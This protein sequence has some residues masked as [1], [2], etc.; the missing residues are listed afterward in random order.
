MEV[1][2][3]RKIHNYRIS[4]EDFWEMLHAKRHNPRLVITLKDKSGKHTHKLSAGY[5]DDID[6]YREGKETFVLSRNPRLDYVGLEVFEGA[7]KQGEIFLQ[8]NQVKEVLG[9]GKLSPFSAVKRL[10]E[11]II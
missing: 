7:E 8:G 9:T 10:V 4:K 11:H 5:Q 6:V 3:M 2:P 1:T